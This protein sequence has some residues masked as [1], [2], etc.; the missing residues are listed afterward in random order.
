[1]AFG[2]KLKPS[3][4]QPGKLIYRDDFNKSKALDK[5]RWQPRQGTARTIRNSV[6]TGIPSPTEYQARKKPQVTGT[7]A[8][9]RA[10]ACSACR[11]NYT[12]TY[13]FKFE[14]GKSSKLTG[15]AS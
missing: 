5:K 8:I 12:L 13:H 3:L 6:L 11:K 15:A 9:Y 2:R 1:M 7:T 10:S 4:L 14:G